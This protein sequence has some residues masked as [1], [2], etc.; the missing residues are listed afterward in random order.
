MFSADPTNPIVQSPY[1][2]NVVTCV[3]VL[4]SAS[5]DIIITLS[6]IFVLK[7]EMRGFNLDTDS[8]MMQCVRLPVRVGRPS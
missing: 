3:W 5:V 1:I 6:L 2:F 4:V 7:S 8:L